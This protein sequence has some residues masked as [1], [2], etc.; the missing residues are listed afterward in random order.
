MRRSAGHPVTSAPPQAWRV[1]SALGAIYVIWG[2]TY[3]AIRVMVETVPPALGAGVRFIL[4]GG[5]ILGLLS[6]RRG[7]P[8]AVAIPGRQLL[9]CALVGALLAAGGNG[10]VTVAER[11]VP[12][13]LAALLVAT[14]PLWIVLY[15]TA[16]GDRVARATLG[17]V[18]LG[19]AGV[20]VLLLPGGRPEHVPIGMALLIV[21]AAA[22]WGLGSLIAPRVDRPRDPLVATGWQMLCGGVVMTA[23]G[24]VAG[25]AGSVH[26]GEFSTKSIFGFAYL[27]VVGS[28]I[29]YSCY[30]YL[31]EH[32]P[33]SQVSTYAYVNPVIAVVLGALLL[34][35][36][37]AP[38]TIA[39]MVLVVA[40]VAVIVRHEARGRP[41]EVAE[42]AE[43]AADAEDQL[44]V[45]TQAGRLWVASRN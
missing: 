28:V 17:G 34:D 25:E 35:E 2:S 5:L 41:A 24:L 40:S 8:R 31:L 37:I 29:A 21:L 6:A 16:A 30:A 44:H 36:H 32:A 27:V 14:V 13:G 1:W 23:G 22:L 12:S 10:L 43:A 33:I 20:G 19:F 9:R 7:G 42:A 26:V 3:L 18:A 15:R 38:A 4:A 39:G 11:D 45:T